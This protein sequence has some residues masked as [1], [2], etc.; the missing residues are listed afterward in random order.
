[1]IK[2]ELKMYQAYDIYKQGVSVI[3]FVKYVNE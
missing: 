2:C 3:V 1:M